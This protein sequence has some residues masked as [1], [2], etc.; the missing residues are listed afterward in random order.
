M[1][2]RFPAPSHTDGYYYY[3]EE[4][5]RLAWRLRWYRKSAARRALYWN[6]TRRMSR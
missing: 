3:V 2:T 4:E 1:T 6:Y 5:P